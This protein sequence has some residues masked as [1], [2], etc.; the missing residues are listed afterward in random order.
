M[1]IY[2]HR[3]ILCVPKVVALT[4]VA[5]NHQTTTGFLSEALHTGLAGHWVLAD[6][7]VF[8]IQ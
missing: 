7:D 5:G 2:M 8:V 3:V 6:P 4:T 1:Y